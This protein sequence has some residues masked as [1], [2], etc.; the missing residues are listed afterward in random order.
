MQE[1]PR[2]DAAC[3][4]RDCDEPAV[5]SVRAPVAADVARSQDGE[6][7]PLCGVHAEQANAPE[8]PPKT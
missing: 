6:M 3:D 5:A 8:S 2:P 4:V 7:V 1:P